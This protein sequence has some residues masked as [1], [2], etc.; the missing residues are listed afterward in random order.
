MDPR[1]R[2]HRR[3]FRQRRRPAQRHH[4]RRNPPA[5]SGAL[6]IIGDQFNSRGTVNIDGAGSRWTNTLG[7]MRVR[8]TS[9]KR[10]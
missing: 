3:R 2:F 4:R 1:Q 10:R 9:D 7:E 5:N 8:F 6:G